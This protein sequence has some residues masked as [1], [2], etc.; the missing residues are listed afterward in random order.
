MWRVLISRIHGNDNI[1]QNGQKF[2]ICNILPTENQMLHWN[3]FGVTIW[4]NRFCLRGGLRIVVCVSDLR[5]A[6]GT[7]G[8][9]ILM[10]NGLLCNMNITLPCTSC[11]SSS[12]QDCYWS[13]CVNITL[14]SVAFFEGSIGTSLIVKQI[15][16]Y[17]WHGNTH[18]LSSYTFYFNWCEIE[19]H[20]VQEGCD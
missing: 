4:R 15:M 6:N 1:P 14:H 11:L 20:K 17:C 16:L 7:A 18:R 5:H 8:V 10:L 12:E 2:G 3:S 9:M 19:M 13:L